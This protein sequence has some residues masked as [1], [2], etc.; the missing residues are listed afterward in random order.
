MLHQTLHSPSH[1]SVAQLVLQLL[2]K[3]TTSCRDSGGSILAIVTLAAPHQQP[4]VNIQASLHA[5]YTRLQRSA[6]GNDSSGKA[7]MDVTARSK[8]RIPLL[9]IAGGMLRFV[10]HTYFPSF[11]CCDPI[12]AVQAQHM[13]TAY[14]TI[15]YSICRGSHADDH[16]WPY[17]RGSDA[18]VQQL[19]I[20]LCCEHMSLMIT[21]VSDGVIAWHLLWLQVVQNQSVP[22]TKH[23]T[24]AMPL[25]VHL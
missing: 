4:P 6:T 20:W 17:R 18:F 2:H 13:P 24:C 1:L 10:N 14:C 15:T 23:V 7:M 22:K 11:V 5:F 8:L 12:N 3:V 16:H 25:C 19:P 9:S 21:C